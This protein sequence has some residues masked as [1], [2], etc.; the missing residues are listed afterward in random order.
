MDIDFL[1]KMGY[2][3][4]LLLMFEYNMRVG[5]I[6]NKIVLLFTSQKLILLH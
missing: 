5:F 6:Y 4:I 2:K 1:P 3:C